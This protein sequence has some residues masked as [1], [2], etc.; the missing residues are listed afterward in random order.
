MGGRLT[1]GQTQPGPSWCT[2]HAGRCLLVATEIRCALW[3]DDTSL[4]PTHSMCLNQGRLWG[5]CG[6]LIVKRVTN[7]RNKASRTMTS[8]APMPLHP[9]APTDVVWSDVILNLAQMGRADAWAMAHG[10]AGLELMAR[11]GQGVARAIIQ[12]WSARPVLVLCGPG[13]NGGDGWVIA[14]ELLLAGWPVKLASACP[15]AQLKGDALQQ[16]LLWPADQAVL[17]LADVSMTDPAMDTVGLVVDA[18]LGAGLARE[19][20]PPVWQLLR[21]V[22]AMGVPVVAVDVPSGLHGDLARPLGD[23]TLPAP[24]DLTVTFMAAKPAH[25]LMPGLAACGELVVVDIGIAPQVLPGLSAPV[26]AATHALPLARRNG[27]GL[28]LHA[29]QP[30]QVSSH[31]YRRGHALVLGGARMIGAARMTARATAR[32]GAGLVTLAVPES[33]WS[34]VASTLMSAMAQGLDD[35]SAQALQ[36]SW[37][38]LLG[39][40]RWASLAIGPG[41]LAGLPL[42]LENAPPEPAGRAQTLQALVLAAL[43]QQDDHAL[44]LDADAL[45]AFEHQPQALFDAIH[46][47]RQVRPNAPEVVL[48]PHEGEFTRLF[49]PADLSPLGGPVDKLSRTRSA[50]SR[51]AAVV[52]HKGPDTVI[53][54]PD[55]RAAINTDAPVW[56]ATAGSGDVLAGF[57][58]GLL[59]Q[60]LGGFEAAC[61]GAWVHAA[62]ARQFG[63]GLL[64]E[65]LPEQVPAVLKKL[66]W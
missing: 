29:W 57:I 8:P 37:Q 40:H 53:A 50:A 5:P 45:M 51:S 31:K 22:R 49:G 6:K 20:D 18:L 41:A 62:C 44:V 42:A 36:Q 65:D 14:R 54:A 15:V 24:A 33:V 13:N 39:S 47:R 55:G 46:A 66:G 64:A 28:W 4:L 56:L 1:G 16:A 7:V 43:R 9:D 63:P 27:P 52:L 23:Q 11:A 2:G 34:V 38:A 58:N 25:L 10:Q 26:G 59:A 60:G 35:R 19:L 48:T 61:A 30:P 32:I 17:A 12:R 21:E 3:A